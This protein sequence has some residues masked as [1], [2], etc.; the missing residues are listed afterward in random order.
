MEVRF[1][2]HNQVDHQVNQEKQFQQVYWKKN[3]ANM[4]PNFSNFSAKTVI[5]KSKVHEY[6]ANT[7]Y[8]CM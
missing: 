1:D 5:S 4:K 3:V 6:G 8:T 2:I 7:V